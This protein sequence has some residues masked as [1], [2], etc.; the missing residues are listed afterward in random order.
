[1]SYDYLFMEEI[2]PLLPDMEERG[3]SEV[4]RGPDGF[5]RQWRKADSDPERLTP[6]W[7]TKRNNF[8]RRHMAYVKKNRTRTSRERQD[9]RDGTWHSSH[10]PIRRTSRGC[11]ATWRDSTLELDMQGLDVPVLGLRI[12]VRL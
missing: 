2:E 9:P 5:L 1:M 8:V 10:G 12:H 11:S 4:A 6:W 3:V 7:A